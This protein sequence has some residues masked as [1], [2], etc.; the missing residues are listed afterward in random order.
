MSKA[1]ILKQIEYYLSD[2][3][4]Q[5]DEFFHE[6]I[7]SSLDGFIPLSLFLKCNKIKKLNVVDEAKI[8]EAVK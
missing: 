2:K 3:N 7:S 8:V 1:E 6:H 5:S 4:L